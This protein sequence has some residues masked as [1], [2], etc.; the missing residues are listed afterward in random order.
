MHP[1]ICPIPSLKVT[2]LSRRIKAR[3]GLE[4]WAFRIA[5]GFSQKGAR[6]TIL[7]S[8]TFEENISKPLIQTHTL[9]LTKWLNFRK[10]DQFNCLTQQWN[11]RHEAAIIFGMDRTCHQTHMRAGNGVH[12]AYLK[13]RKT[14]E[15]YPSYKT[16]LKPL[17]QT[18]LK[19]EKEA[20][21]NP[22]LKVLFANSYMVKNEILEH[23]QVRPDKIE[24]IHNGAPWKDMEKDF[25]S[26]V[27]NKQKECTKQH[28]DPTL[29]HFLF[30]GNGY[31]RKGLSSLL[32][33][34][35]TLKNKEFHLSVLGK[36]RKIDRFI[37]LAKSL[38][39]EKQVRFF[40]PVS[41][42]CPFFQIADCL[43]IPSYYDPFANVTVEALAMGLFVVSSKSNGG[44]EIL[45]E[46]TG[47]II[48]NLAAIDSLRTSLEHAMLAPKTWMRSQAIRESV[49]HL[50]FSNQIASY[51]KRSLERQ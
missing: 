31:E 21:E 16:F 38:R 18:I 44:H 37:K 42:V 23:Y 25:I 5:E 4:K 50:D 35:A 2:I 8:D 49:K 40:G 19:L 27:E 15:N 45:K 10:M 46:D 43:V 41:D 48:E 33:A 36:D 9:P 14:F 39:L 26:W 34:L 30:I 24:V 11:Q 7:T 20:F 13:Q 1:N 47:T 28:L 29:Y 6:V 22:G 3:G 32:R 51:I 12:A 17:N